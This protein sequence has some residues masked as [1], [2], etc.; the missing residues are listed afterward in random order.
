MPQS[1]AAPHVRPR[2]TATQAFR[3]FPMQYRKLIVPACLASLGLGTLVGSFAVAEQ[4][5]NDAAAQPA[6]AAEQPEMKLPPG[7]TAADMQACAMAAA[8]GEQHKQLT[9]DA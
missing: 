6:A 5:K 2:Q 3:R 1:R 9:A 8:P 7:W 4:P